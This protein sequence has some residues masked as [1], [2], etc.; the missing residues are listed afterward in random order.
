MIGWNYR[1]VGSSWTI[2]ILKEIITSHR[3]DLLFL[4]ETLIVSNKIEALASKLGFVNYFSVDKQGNG[5]GLAMFWKHNLVCNVFD[6]STNHIDLIVKKRNGGEWRLM[7]FYGYPERERRQESWSF[8]R[9]LASVSTLSWCV[10]G[11][12]NDL[13]HDDEKKGRDKHP[14]NLLDGFRNTIED[15][16]LIEVDLKGGDFT[17]EKSKGTEN[18]VREKLDMCFA[19]SEWWSKFPLY[20]L[21]VFHTIVSDHE[22]IKLE[23]VNTKI[24]KTQFWF[25]FENTWIKESS[26]HS[27]VPSFWKNLSS[28]HLLPKLIEVS[29]YIAKWGMGFFHKFRKK[30]ITQK[31]I[32]DSLKGKEDDDGVQMYFDEKNKLDELLSH[33]EAYWKQS[34]KIFWL[35]DGDTNSKLFHAAASSRKKLNYLTGLKDEDGS[36]IT[37]HDGMCNLLKNYFTKVFSEDGGGPVSTSCDFVLMVSGSQNSKLTED[38]SFSEFTQAVKSMH[39]D[40]ASGPDDLNPAFF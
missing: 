30:V 8:F 32:I 25:R 20:T 26:F 19:N 7:G 16:S 13:M 11:D 12:F 17:W 9:T 31:E 24:P 5:G 21:T 35:K 2:R 22:P 6:S 10:L 40:K 39:P 34:A 18:W 38:L 36:L 33:E 4:S 3:P 23:L 15:C 28:M 27:E 29:K 1:G 37:N 14:Q